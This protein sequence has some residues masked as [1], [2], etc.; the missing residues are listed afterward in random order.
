MWDGV[1]LN[2]L[3]HSSSYVRIQVFTAWHRFSAIHAYK[4]SET[5][6]W[7]TSA[8]QHLDRSKFSF[9]MVPTEL[10]NNL[11]VIDTLTKHTYKCP[12][13]A[14]YTNIKNMYYNVWFQEFCFEV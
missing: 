9:K 13:T 11:L 14:P 12:N 4:K 10:P 2:D 7:V 8:R 5:R 1:N 6:Q 3:T